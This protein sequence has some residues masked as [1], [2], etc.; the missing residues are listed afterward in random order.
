MVHME[1]KQN[2]RFLSVKEKYLRV[3]YYTV[4]LTE[5]DPSSPVRLYKQ[6]N[7][8]ADLEQTVTHDDTAYDDI[9]WSQTDTC[10]IANHRNLHMDDAESHEIMDLRHNLSYLLDSIDPSNQCKTHSTYQS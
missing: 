6:T 10:D 7:E 8:K 5:Q 1:E 3:Y 2:V 9:S 4:D